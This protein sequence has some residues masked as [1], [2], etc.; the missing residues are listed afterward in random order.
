MKSSCIHESWKEISL[1]PQKQNTIRDALDFVIRNSRASQ[2]FVS[3]KFWLISFST[4][5]LPI[6]ETVEQLSAVL[7]S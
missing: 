5:I 6:W 7:K 1:L 3:L 2:G 4:V